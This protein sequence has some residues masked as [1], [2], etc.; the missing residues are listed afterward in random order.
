MDKTK[1]IASISKMVEK[2]AYSR[3]PD[4]RLVE[5]KPGY[6]NFEMAFS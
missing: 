1:V 5:L 4:M 2:E 6:A 3:K